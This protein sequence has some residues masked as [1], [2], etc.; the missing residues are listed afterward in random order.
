M[1]TDQTGHLA[2]YLALFASIGACLATGWQALVARGALSAT[3]DQINILKEQINDLL[4]ARRGKIYKLKRA[5]DSLYDEC[6]DIPDAP[7]ITRE[8]I[9]KL[10]L[11]RFS[12]IEASCDTFFFKEITAV[13]HLSGKLS[14]LD[15]ATQD[16]QTDVQRLLA[17]PESKKKRRSMPLRLR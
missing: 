1:Q 17:Q 14:E 10:N 11:G 15:Q 7:D 2:A 13:R 9:K 8:D 4:E 5:I 12:A 6:Q 3:R 16:G